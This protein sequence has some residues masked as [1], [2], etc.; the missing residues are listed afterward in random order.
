MEEIMKNLKLI[1]VILIVL[2]IVQLSAQNRID[3]KYIIRTFIDED[4]NSIDEIIVPGRPPEFH[5]EPAVEL[6]DPSTSDA[7]NIL[8]NIPAFDWVYG[9]SATSAAMMTGHYDNTI[10]P[11]MYTGP[12]N[13]GVVPMNNSTWGAGECPLSAT[14]MGYDGLSV[15]GHVDD[16]WIAYG[17]TANDPYITGG[18]TA[19][20]NA[21]CTADYMG[22]NQSALGNTDGATTFYFNG[23]G[24]PLY[25]YTGCEPG[26]K[27]GC[28]GLR[29]FF[30][31]RG[32]S[33]QTNGNYS[34]YINPYNS[35]GFTYAQFKAEI[36]AGRPVLIQ[37]EGHTML[38]Y[39]YNDT[40]TTIYIHDTWDHNNHTMTWGGSYSGMAHYGVGVFLLEDPSIT[41]TAPNGGESWDMG[42]TYS[43][44][45]TSQYVSNV[46]IDLYNSGSYVMTI[47]GSYPAGSGTFSWPIPTG[48]TAG[49]TYR[50]RISDSDAAT[51]YDESNADFTINAAST[52]NPVIDVT[53]TS[54]TAT[55]EMNQ[56]DSQQMFISNIGDPGSTLT[57]SLSHGFTDG[58]D[59]ITGSYIICIPNTFTAGQT[60]TWN[61]TVYN[62]STDV[63]WLTDIYVDFPAGVTVNSGTDFTGGHSDLV[64]DGTTGNGAY[65][66][67]YDNNGGY[68]NIWGGET[69]SASVNVTIN[70]SFVGD[71]TLY[72]QIVGD[73]WGSAPHTVNGSTTLTQQFTETWLSYN[74]NSGSCNQ[75]ETD[76]IDIAFDS[77]GLTAGTYTADILI[78]N[79]G[80]GPVIIPCTLNVIYPPDIDVDPA[81]FTE[82]LDTGDT[83]TQILTISNNG[84]ENLFVSLSI[85]ETTD[86]LPLYIKPSNDVTADGTS[87]RSGPVQ[88][89]VIGPDGYLNA[90]QEMMNQ[91]GQRSV[92]FADDMESGVNG[93]I[94]QLYTG[95][96]DDLWHQTNINYNSETTSWWC[97]IE[98]QND[99]S[100][101]N[102]I[103]TAVIS[104]AIDLTG[105]TENT[106]LYF[107]ENYET[108]AGYDKCMVDI[109]INGGTSWIPLRG[110][111]STAPSGSSGGWI[112]TTLDLTSYIG[113]V[114][115]IRFYF[116]TLD[117]VANNYAGWF[118]DDII[119]SSE[120]FS[121]SISW[122]SLSS[123]AAYIPAFSDPATFDVNFDATSLI[124]GTY[125]A[126]I[127]I[128]SNDP[129]EP[130]IIAPVTLEINNN[131]PTIVLPDDFTFTEDGSL[132]VDFD[133][134]VNDIDGDPLT[135]SYAG[136]TNVNVSI[137]GLIVT[138][139]AAQDW[140]G[141][142]I[143]TFT[144]NDGQ[145]D[146]A[147]ADVVNVIVTPVN[148][149]PI[150]NITGTFEADED[151]PSVTYD[152][153]GYC[154]QT[155]GETDALT[156]SAAGSA[157]IDVTV[158][159][160]DVVFESNKRSIL[161]IM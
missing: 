131:T 98:G 142:E 33:I 95:T 137:A 37:V 45:W 61:L 139:T 64:Y 32:Y 104:P 81:S 107:Y 138:L 77:S 93:W 118:F 25:D 39:G 87:H 105:V 145:T 80:G 143:L 116:D 13:G 70:P 20:S 155:W 50:I 147:A 121:P 85:E 89:N 17:S 73:Q 11:Q 2:T 3:S 9:C 86:E 158:T 36:D 100:T 149:P 8:P 38:G 7:I 92:F 99:Y 128:D 22:T 60:T 117:S 96:T 1:L 46:N 10:F 123:N 88:P 103:N 34:Q 30:E 57:Y 157:H 82:N 134:Y 41:V 53:P 97:G 159:G 79:N 110:N 23:S 12:T 126:N 27:D 6:P 115:N 102:R 58:M 109:S 90:F 65:L 15:R 160:F 129:D 94:T 54:F 5:R 43:I 78:T 130:Q 150:L 119:I 44:T 40:G 127:I 52:I 24:A 135:L 75:G 140:Y 136:N 49:S 62:A 72:Y 42:S 19:H 63:E 68:G 161:M 71:V 35:N 18:W 122:L 146:A 108:E 111:Y 21:D 101:G 113:N 4:G 91:L 124:R 148:D 153:S 106:Y 141:T 76:I 114:I 29:Q 151:L 120:S 84:G 14:H 144:V 28:H 16:Y 26:Q 154:S 51:T 31:S 59:N 152:F 67:W 125:T 55:L 69:A 47:V 112:L 48:L 56:T 66:H 83:S 74:P 156:L 132:V 133:L